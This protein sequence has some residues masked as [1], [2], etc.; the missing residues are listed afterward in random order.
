MIFHAARLVAPAFVHTLW[1]MLAEISQHVPPIQ[2][3]RA[4][5]HIMWANERIGARSLSLLLSVVLPERALVLVVY[6]CLQLLTALCFGE[7]NGVGRKEKGG[8]KNDALRRRFSLE[9]GFIFFFSI[10]TL[11][12]VVRRRCN[13]AALV[14]MI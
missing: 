5:T 9:R 4:L 10:L 11:R 12:R 2:S 6:F 14:G 7:W 3:R 13:T 1:P 8:G